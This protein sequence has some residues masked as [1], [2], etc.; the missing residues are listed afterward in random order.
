YDHTYKLT[1]GGR[2]Y[3]KAYQNLPGDLKVSFRAGLLNYDI[4]GCSL[5]CLN[6]LFKRYDIGY[7]VDSALYQTIMEKSG[8]ERKQCKELVL[9]TIYRI[10]KVTIGIQNG[11]GEDVY[12][13]LDNN[14]AKTK[15]LLAWWK[16]K[17]KPLR[18]ALGRLVRRIKRQHH[19]KCASPRQYHLY[20]NDIGLVLNLKQEKYER[21]DDNGSTTYSKFAQNKGLL[22]HMVT[23]IEQAYIREVIRLNSNKICMLDHDGFAAID[24]IV[25]PEHEFIRLELKK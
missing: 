4:A 25:Q 15:E 1:F 8:L 18:I 7:R 19:Q 16:Q 13:W 12:H 17:A 3:D 14:E 2:Y 21:K 22:T 6:T 23:G 9:A 10:G 24:E 11:I 20:P 5:A